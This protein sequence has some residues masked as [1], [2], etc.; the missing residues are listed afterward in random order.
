MKRYFLMGFAIKDSGSPDWKFENVAM[1]FGSAEGPVEYLAE[2]LTI[3]DT[4]TVM[5]FC[6]EITQEQYKKLEGKLS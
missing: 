5:N 2:L 4:T 6:Q 1:E 3:P